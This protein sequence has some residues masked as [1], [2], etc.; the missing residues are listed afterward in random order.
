MLR[1]GAIGQILTYLVSA[2]RRGEVFVAHV[3]GGVDGGAEGECFLPCTLRGQ[4]L[5]SQ[6]HIVTLAV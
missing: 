3:H 6:N 2:R 4:T 5:H 1:K